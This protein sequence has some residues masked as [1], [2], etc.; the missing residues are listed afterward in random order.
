MVRKIE[1]KEKKNLN[2]CK[3]RGD[4]F[5]LKVW[6]QFYTGSP[7]DKV[8]NVKKETGLASARIRAAQTHLKGPSLVG[9]SDKT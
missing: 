5:C 6:R 2:M 4:L 3:I 7:W 1:K 8:T 9:K